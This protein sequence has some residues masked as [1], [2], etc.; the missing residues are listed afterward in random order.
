VSFNFTPSQWQEI[1]SAAVA[2][3]TQPSLIS[4]E[5]LTSIANDYLKEGSRH[6]SPYQRRAAWTR[7]AR[8]LGEARAALASAE[9]IEDPRRLL[10]IYAEARGPR[11][12]TQLDSWR[13]CALNMALYYAAMR[14]PRDEF[15]KGILRCWMESGGLLRLSR[16][17]PSDRYAGKLGGPL[18][19]YL[20]AV[21]EPVMGTGAPT[22]EGLRK[23]VERYAKEFEE[24]LSTDAT[25]AAW[26][27]AAQR[28]ADP[29]E[30]ATE[31][32]DRI[33][34][35]AQADVDDATIARSSRQPQERRSQ[36]ISQ[37]AARRLVR[38]PRLIPL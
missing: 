25:E 14:H 37:M 16:K 30:A 3:C 15:F 32:T 22:S 8:L 4:R 6:V 7:I 34:A 33:V 21:V 1:R 26:V 11:I 10:H 31:A 20:R 17:S 36:R 29:H 13:Q 2:G 27:S 35:K 12:L 24:W 38:G 19:R 5:A 23:I 18:I 9:E 28:G